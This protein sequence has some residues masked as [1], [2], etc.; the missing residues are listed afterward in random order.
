MIISGKSIFNAWHSYLDILLVNRNG[1][2]I[3]QHVLVIISYYV[4][5]V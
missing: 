3:G 2:C 5:R 4:D 1:A